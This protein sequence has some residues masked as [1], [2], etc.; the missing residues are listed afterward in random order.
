[1]INHFSVISSI[2]VIK[3]CILKVLD[4]LEH[5]MFGE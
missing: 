1:M 5:L 3:L 2:I 4:N